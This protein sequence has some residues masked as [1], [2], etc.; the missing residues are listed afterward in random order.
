MKSTDKSL[1]KE[2]K[3]ENGNTG[4]RRKNGQEMGSLEIRPFDRTSP[5]LEEAHALY[6]QSFPKYERKP[7]EMILSGQQQGKMEPYSIFVNGEYAGLVFLIPG[8]QVDVL[9]Y[10]A[11]APSMQGQKIGSRVLQWLMENRSKP[12]L[13]EIESTRIGSDQT[14]QRRKAFYLANG[15]HDCKEQIRL[16]GV[17]M[18]LL[19]S[20]RPVT[21]E[22]YFQTMN[23][24]FGRSASLWIHHE[25]QRSKL[26]GKPE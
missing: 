4:D 26:S 7:F 16:F 14:K 24:Y 10:L 18:E 1:N 5:E 23:H 19:S 20:I 6:H 9:D 25:I 12:F 13:V 15:M 11:I 2:N 17:E 21:F 22:E 3:P 8:E